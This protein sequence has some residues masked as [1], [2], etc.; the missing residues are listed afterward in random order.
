M[1]D[2]IV[3]ALAVIGAHSVAFLIYVA[4]KSGDFRIE[5]SLAIQA[6]PET[7]YPL[8]NDLHKFNSWNPFV[9][10]DPD[11]KI[12]YS[13]PANGSGAA[14][15]WN[16]K[17]SGAGRIQ[18]MTSQPASKV[19]IQLQFMKPFAATNA[20][21][22]TLAPRGATTT[23]TWAMSCTRH[24]A[25]KLMGTIFNMDKMV[26]GEFAKGLANLKPMAEK[27]AA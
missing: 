11:A 3:P 8:I 4:M 5:R 27:P 24:F 15:D 7:I 14:Y 6:P 1:L 21:E 26:G 19:A 23:V 9:L 25:H 2:F 13:G 20:A 18:I 10:S 17:K 12:D 16:G 22:F